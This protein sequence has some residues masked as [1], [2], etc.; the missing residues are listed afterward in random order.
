M[1]FIKKRKNYLF[2]VSMCFKKTPY[3]SSKI[4]SKIIS[5]M[6]S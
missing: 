1:Y 4:S 6:L 3:K 5:F 2:C